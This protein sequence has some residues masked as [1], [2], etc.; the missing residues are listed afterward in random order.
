M[1]TPLPELQRGEGAVLSKSSEK[2]DSNG[3]TEVNKQTSPVLMFLYF[4]KAIRNELHA[5]HTLAMAFA[6]GQTVDVTSLF[7]RY[8]FLRLI[9]EHHSSAEDEVL[10]ILFILLFVSFFY[11]C[12]LQHFGM[13][14]V[15]LLQFLSICRC[16]YKLSFS[17][18]NWLLDSLIFIYYVFS[19]SR[20]WM[21]ILVSL[22][23]M[24]AFNLEICFTSY[25]YWLVALL[26]LVFLVF[27]IL[28]ED[29]D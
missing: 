25:I 7:E 10:L 13:Y 20:L 21:M 18:S 15:F 23:I 1:A 12:F 14:W 9:Y 24:F 8:R 11:F 6:V 22:L 4:H 3:C 16:R 27:S 26:D 29:D 17:F 19:D 2:V 5:L 28:L